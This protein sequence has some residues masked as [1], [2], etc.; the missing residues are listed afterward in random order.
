MKE[1]YDGKGYL[2][3]CGDSVYDP[4]FIEPAVADQLYSELCREAFVDPDTGAV[5]QGREM[6]TQDAIVEASGK[7]LSGT[8]IASTD[9]TFLHPRESRQTWNRFKKQWSVMPHRH[10]LFASNENVDMGDRFVRNHTLNNVDSMQP[11]FPFEKSPTV[12][13][14]RNDL[15]DYLNGSR[16]HPRSLPRGFLNM[17]NVNLYSSGDKLGPHPDGDDDGNPPNKT[18]GEWKMGEHIVRTVSLGAPRNYTIYNPDGKNPKKVL[19]I[20]VRA[21][22]V[23]MLGHQT[24]AKYYHGIPETKAKNVRPR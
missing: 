10:T 24:N 9:T 2:E 7:T 23:N 17:C 22:S 1:N 16:E 15:E 6:Q 19:S 21:G 11:P 5:L 14:I 4:G 3:Y 20:K 18:N 12:L 13:K 8:A